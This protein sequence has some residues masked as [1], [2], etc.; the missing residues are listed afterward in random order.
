[1]SSS[2]LA[3]LRRKYPAVGRKADHENSRSNAIKLFCLGCVGGSR[4]EVASC[5][6]YDCPLWP[7]R[8]YGDTGARPDGVVPTADEYREW[9]PDG[10]GAF[11]RDTEGE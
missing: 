8:P 10:D 7:F 1:M 9:A 6:G 3:G 4:S 11:G 2:I 5:T